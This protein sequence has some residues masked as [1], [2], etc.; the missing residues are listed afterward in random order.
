[1]GKDASDADVQTVWLAL[2]RTFM[3]AVDAVDNGVN[4]FDTTAEP[5][6]VQARRPSP[7]PPARPHAPAGLS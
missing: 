1:M 4:Q 2:Y 7:S 3:E 6:Y 5:R